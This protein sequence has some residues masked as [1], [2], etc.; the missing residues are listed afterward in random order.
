VDIEN[1]LG[2]ANPRCHEVAEIAR[3]YAA[4]AGVAP[5]DHV[6]IASSHHCAESAWFGWP[7]NARRLVR[8]GPNGADRA[9]VEVLEHEEVERRFPRVVM[10]SGDGL[11]A[12]ASARLQAGGVEVTVVTRAGSLSGRL[13]LATLDVRFIDD[14]PAEGA[15]IAIRGAA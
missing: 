15:T 9:L 3:L 8:S 2:T 1:L 4:V 14:L 13:R 10:G 5:G 6:V 11:F 12:E 7:P